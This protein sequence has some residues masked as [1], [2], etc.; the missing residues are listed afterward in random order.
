MR[1]E[2]QG[3]VQVGRADARGI[4]NSMMTHWRG[5]QQAKENSVEGGKGGVNNR[6]RKT[7]IPQ[8]SHATFF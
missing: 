6:R 8:D 5:R 4:R 7:N 1:A 3:A 2:M